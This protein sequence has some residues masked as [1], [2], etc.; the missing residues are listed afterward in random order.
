MDIPVPSARGEGEDGPQHEERD[1]EDPANH[2]LVESGARG[3]RGGRSM[4]SFS[5]GSK[6]SN[7]TQEDR[8]GH[9][10]PEDLN[11]EDRQGRP[12]EDGGQDDEPFAAVRRERPDD[13]LHKVVEDPFAPPPRPG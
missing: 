7:Q 11:G 1:Q 9:V 6:A 3:S 10:D 2:H 5:W 4:T 12:R 13:E 8:R